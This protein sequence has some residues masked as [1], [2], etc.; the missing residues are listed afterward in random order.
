MKRK[1][2]LIKLYIKTLAIF[3]CIGFIGLGCV[4][5]FAGND[6]DDSEKASEVASKFV[7]KVQSV[8]ASDSD[9]EETEE[10]PDEEKN[11]SNVNSSAFGGGVLSS[12][13]DINLHSVDGGT[14]NYAFTYNGTE[15]SAIY[16][17]DNWKVIDSYLIDNTEDITIICEA[18]I[19]EHP[20]HGSDM[21]SYRTADDMAYEWEQHNLAY[22]FLPEGNRWKEKTKD[23]DLNPADQGLSFD[24]I[25]ERQTGKKLSIE[26][27][28]KHI[29]N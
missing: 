8:M 23:V 9:E 27:L 28:L 25:Y 16:T 18:L 26:E 4:M 12:P 3:L 24:E 14:K 6:S 10:T 13:A 21:Q 17:A 7:S 15:F 2:S 29:S 22:K 19:A 20:V 5:L 11:E 1:K